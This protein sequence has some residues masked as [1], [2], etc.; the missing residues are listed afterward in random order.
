[1]GKCICN[2]YLC[3]DCNHIYEQDEPSDLMPLLSAHWSVE[4]KVDGKR[5]L[6]IEK[7]SLGGIENINDYKFYIQECA[8]ALLSFIGHEST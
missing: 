6:T 5:I 2:S 7:D 8:S 3:P 4:I 1:M